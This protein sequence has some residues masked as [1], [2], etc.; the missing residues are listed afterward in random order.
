L[1]S[2]LRGRLTSFRSFLG[3]RL[4]LRCYNDQIQSIT[5]N[6]DSTRS[7]TYVYDA[8]ARLKSATNAQRTPEA[9]TAR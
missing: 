1:A 4:G 2:S 5:D 9:T 6:V 7:T 8:W 3:R